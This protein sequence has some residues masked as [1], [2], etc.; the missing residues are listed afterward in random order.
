[1]TD[2][3]RTAQRIEKLQALLEGG[4]ARLRPRKGRV[5]D[6]RERLETSLKRARIVQR[7][8]ALRGVKG[9]E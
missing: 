4:S 8:Y 7:A 5:L 1:M 6:R 9:E 2:G 3:E